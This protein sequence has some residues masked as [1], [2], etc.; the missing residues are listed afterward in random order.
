MMKSLFICAILLICLS[1]SANAH[2]ECVS[3]QI[4]P[5]L[6]GSNSSHHRLA[7]R[8]AGAGIKIRPVDSKIEPI[9]NGGYTIETH[10]HVV[11]DG[12]NGKLTEA[13]VR[14]NIEVVNNIFQS[15]KAPFRFNLVG[16]N[17]VQND[18]W[19]K[20][21]RSL[22][23]E[24]S[25]RRLFSN[26]WDPVSELEKD[27]KR[28][29]RKGGK[30]VLNIWSADSAVTTWKLFGFEGRR[31]RTSWGTFPWN[32]EP[33]ADGVVVALGHLKG[34]NQTGAAA[35]HEL[36]HW[37]GLYHPFTNG[38]NPTSDGDG[39]DDTPAV[40]SAL[41]YKQHLNCEKPVDSCPNQPGTDQ[42]TNVM[43]YVVSSC[44]KVFTP[45]QID[46]MVRVWQQFRAK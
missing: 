37:L 15:N 30:S 32:P 43:D 12:A 14:E 22:L 17:Y 36:G 16:I 44:M 21:S 5:P 3:E 26:P 29:T 2:Y 8:Q 46:R 19:F 18:K 25:L 20:I 38:C 28:Q 34:P 41:R 4:Q 1:Q 24:F 23:P 45:G 6:P 35:A 9:P 40:D 10:W 11:H 31:A 33:V 42:L 7:R 39:V 27:M 13:Q